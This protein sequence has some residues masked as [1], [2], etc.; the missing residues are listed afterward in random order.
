MLS[1]TWS[2]TLL[3]LEALP[4]TVEVDCSPGLPHLTI[5]GLPDQ[6]VKEA[7]ER[8]RGALLNSGYTLPRQRLTVN[9]SPADL[10][11]EGGQFDLAIALGILAVS[12]Q[13]DPSALAEVIA[14]GELGLDGS[15]RSTP[16]ILSMALAARAA[17]G[18]RALL[19]PALNAAEAMDGVGA[20]IGVSSLRDAVE[21]LAGLPAPSA[22]RQAG[23]SE[24]AAVSPAPPPDPGPSPRAPLD[25]SDVKG[26]T[27][28]KRALEIAVAGGHHALLI[29]PPGSGKSMLAQRLPSI[30]PDLSEEESLQVTLIHSVMGLLTPRQGRLRSRPFRAPH[31]TSS[32]IA[33]VGGGPDVRPGEISLAHHGVL[34]LDELPEFRREA[35]ESLRQPLEEGTVRVA[36]ARR[37]CLFP[38]RVMLV[39]AM[40]PCPCGHLGD[41]AHNCRC[42][43]AEIQRY[44]AKI[45][46]PLLDRL[47]LHVE[48][49]AVPAAALRRSAPAEAS[50]AIQARVLQA[51]ARQRERFAASEVFTNA[52]MRPADL[53]RWCALTPEGDALLEAALRELGLSA[54]AHDKILK[55]ARTIADLA[56][57]EAI[58][59]EHLAEAIQYR[60]L[61]RQLWA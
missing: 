45:S 33:L 59:P 19:V 53:P 14:V 52:Q 12:G 11:K 44:R 3:G 29:G 6:A 32:A 9:L 20:V 56:D 60:S 50:R 1:R 49:P 7:R 15:L 27:L 16:G 17:N 48:V 61:D 23:R 26:Q 4:I 28:A 18:H 34:F 31:H 36:R 42:A 10:R 55:V 25:F 37:T 35:L 5:V 13:L 43:P 51:R 58:Q 41:A 22:V 46:G 39:A 8:V 57:A 38:S 24:A 54:R 40:N 2:Y 21:H 30:Q 47:D